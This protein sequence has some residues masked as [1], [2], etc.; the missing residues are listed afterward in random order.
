MV[1]GFLS[2]KPSPAALNCGCTGCNDAA[3]AGSVTYPDAAGVCGTTEASSVTGA[4]ATLTKTMALVVPEDCTVN[5]NACM[6]DRG[7]CSGSTHGPGMDG[8]DQFSIVGAGGILN[9]N[10]GIIT[11]A[12]NTNTCVT[13][14]QVGGTLTMN[15]TANRVAEL[16]TY[17]LAYTGASCQPGPLFLNLVSFNVYRKSGG[18]MID[19][20][21]FGQHNL[22]GFE[23]EHSSNGAEFVALKE[24]KE[25]G[26]SNQL[27]FYS[28]FIEGDF[29]E[30]QNYFRL[31]QNHNDGT[32]SYSQVIFEGANRSDVVNIYPNP[33]SSGAFY[34][35]PPDINLD[36]FSFEV[37]DFSGR[38]VI[39]D[40]RI[41]EPTLID[42]RAFPKGIYL[43][44][45]TDAGKI[46]SKKIVYD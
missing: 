15:L 37:L 3:Y 18:M 20:A 28:E 25:K 31:R 10:S 21:I 14:T 29:N 16:L 19:W 33:S 8:G 7:S 30:D 42:L 12:S 26:R 44:R 6:G 39:R 22:S 27:Q 5:I 2:I 46:Y 45:I 9:C 1:T 41:N 36:G 24:I 38:C 11:G 13:L 32:F 4:C 35:F 17:T 23:I 34:L 40:E 43:C